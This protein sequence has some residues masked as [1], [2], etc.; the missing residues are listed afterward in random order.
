MKCIYCNTDNN[1]KDRQGNRQ[2]CKSCHHPFAFEPKTDSYGINDMQFARAIKDVSAD[3]TLAFTP[4]HLWYEINRRLLARKVISCGTAVLVLLACVVLSRR[5]SP[6]LPILCVGLG[7]MAAVPRKPKVKGPRTVKM[8]FE[9]FER[10]YLQ[11]WINTHGQVARLLPPANRHARTYSGQ[12]DAPD[13]SAYSFDRALITDHSEI[14]AM[15]VANNFHFENNCA[16]LSLHGY[17]FQAADTIKTMLA[18]NPNLKVFALHDASIEGTQLGKTLRNNDWFPDRNVRIIDLGLRPMHVIRG[19]LIALHG[20]PLKFP[21]GTTS[22]SLTAEEIAWLEQGN[23]AEL[24]AM[25]PAK[26]MRAVYQGFARAA[27]TDIATVD[28]NGVVIIDSGPSI[29]VYDGGADVYA[30]DSFG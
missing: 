27:Q 11:R 26:L 13:V 10:N 22:T 16:I 12:A 6:L 2:S 21:T 29:W 25:R 20:P 4:R 7:M 9:T 28:D 24:Y 8:P 5:H 19:G 1:Y 3:G 17:P 15:L 18:R 23:S 14:A 30:S